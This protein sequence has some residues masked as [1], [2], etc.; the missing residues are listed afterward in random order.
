MNREP[1][2]LY[3]FR[4]FAGLAMV[5][6]MAMLYWSS[7]LQETQLIQMR[8]TIQEIQRRL[9]DLQTQGIRVSKQ[10]TIEQ[11]LAHADMSLPNLL[12]ADP[13]YDATLPELLGSEFKPHGI[14]E[15]STVTRPQNLSPFSGWAD[16]SAW[17]S[18]CTVSVAQGQIGKYETLAPDMA[19][20]MEERGVGT[21]NHEFWI[22][23]RDNVY[24]QP[25]NPGMFQGGVT[26]APHFLKRHQVTAEDF[27]FFFDV[28]MNPY[29]QELGALS[30]RTTLS[31]I[32]EIEVIDKLTFVVRW[33]THEIDGTPKILYRAR[34][35]TGSLQPL[36]GFVYKYFPDGTKIVE[37]DSEKD[38]YRTSSLWGQNFMEHWA[39][40]IIVSCGRWIFE[41]MSDQAIRFKRNPDF[42][43]P[44]AALAQNITVTFKES[45]S[46]VWQ[47]FKSNKLDYHVL[48]PDQNAELKDFLNSPQYL[49]Q[50]EKDSAIERLEYIARMYTY[51]GWNQT[52]PYFRSA[53]VRQAL[54]MSIDRDRIIKQNLN[55][56]AIPITGTFFRFSP[57][58]DDTI[59]PWPFDPQRARNL[60]A[61]EGWYDSDGDGIIDKE[62]DGKRVPF[63]FQLTYYVKNPITKAICDYIATAL[64]EV[65][66]DCRLLGVDLSDL[67]AA[68]EEKNFDAYFLAWGLSTPPEDPRQ[69]WSSAGAKERGSSNT[70][71]FVNTEVDQIIE[72]LEYESNRETR[73]KL[74]HRF[75]RILHEEQPY[76]FLYT[77]KT[78]M[79]Y[80]EYLKN[81]FIPADNQ[82][83]I[84]GANVTEPQEQIFYLDKQE[85]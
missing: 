1:L 29:V 64:K 37:D 45:P 15:R 80:R 44:L 49:S 82:K 69:L 70:V 9:E 20:R 81:V 34:M 51:I 35:L 52:K 53:K 6:L 68:V 32:K 24:W 36:P 21:E 85:G 62:I 8:Q 19:I 23:L 10:D 5:A 39:R 16:V 47:D 57:A 38:T 77:P 18:L 43:E 66:I 13:F 17:N 48:L 12:D 25:L 84:P 11:E 60:L 54:T 63:S 67:S 40:N 55:G 71:G 83:L 14:F 50:K 26:L 2:L 74:Y 28:F 76:T 58:Y 4:F 46:N 65:G 79:L 56:Y 33:K 61:E 22:F 27:K 31:E 75:N 7:T 59:Q 42:Y 78:I 73:I 30:L 41:Q 72:Q 3:F